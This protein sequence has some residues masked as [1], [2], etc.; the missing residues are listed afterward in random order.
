MNLKTYLNHISCG[1]GQ[2]NFLEW[3]LD[4]V[5]VAVVS[6]AGHGN[7]ERIIILEDGGDLASPDLNFASL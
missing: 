5:G 4:P 3:H 6:S 7:G 1:V 2:T